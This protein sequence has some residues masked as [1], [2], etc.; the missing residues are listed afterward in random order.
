[1]VRQNTLSEAMEEKG[2]IPSY[3]KKELGDISDNLNSSEEKDL[4]N[5]RT[6]IKGSMGLSAAQEFDKYVKEMKK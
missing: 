6:R 4:I 3:L 5:M 1:M 2:D